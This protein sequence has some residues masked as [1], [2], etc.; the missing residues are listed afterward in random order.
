MRWTSRPPAPT[1]CVWRRSR[2]DGRGRLA[3]PWLLPSTSADPQPPV[4]HRRPAARP[5]WARSS[6]GSSWCRARKLAWLVNTSLSWCRRWRWAW[7]QRCCR[8]SRP[9]L[10]PRDGTAVHCGR[11][12]L[13]QPRRGLPDAE[14]YLIERASHY[15]QDA[16]SPSASYWPPCWYSPAPVAGWP[17]AAAAQ[18]AARRGARRTRRARC[19]SASPL[20]ASIRCWR[21]RPAGLDPV[22]FRRAAGGDAL[23]VVLGMPMALGL[24]RFAGQA[25]PCFPGPGR[26]MARAR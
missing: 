8:S 4:L 6:S 22:R 11:V 2:S 17:R 12:L 9:A 26:S 20:P 13:R 25:W 5:S 7:R 21:R 19:G 14:I 24:G 16:P 1:C 3:V 18:S 10:R 23:A 15:L